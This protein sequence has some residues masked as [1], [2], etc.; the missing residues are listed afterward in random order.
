VSDSR[1][2]GA[3]RPR[4]CPKRVPTFIVI[5][6]AKCGTTS[7]A[8][9]LGDHPEV[10]LTSP[11]EPHYFSRL[12]RYRKL[13]PWYTSLFEGAGS[14]A[15]AG[16]AST[17]YSH[18]HRIDFVAPR[19]RE[20]VPDCRLV[21]MVRHPIRRL[22]SDWKMRLRENRV[23]ASISE[24]ADHHASLISFGLYWKHVETYREYF[25]DD[26]LLVVFLE[27]FAADPR[28]ELARIFRHI[29]VDPTVIP[30]DPGRQRNAANQYRR[31]GMVA[32]VLTAALR[33]LDEY[34]RLRRHLPDW[35][36]GPVKSLLTE[37]FEASP[38]W[39]P[40]ALATVREY[41]RED[42]RQLLRHCGKPLDYWELE[43]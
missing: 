33:R 21:Y 29:R 10:F 23:P 6:A 11:K 9:V 1:P 17:S 37:P 22:E 3:E 18:P 35:L 19:I 38:D 41:Y 8:D 32:K 2:P 31:K 36:R 40:D 4:D 28:R 26:Q 39:E 14:F 42:S 30:D 43:E 27:D 25:P 7:I 5:G 15:A 34:G 20:V 13:R 16:E 12:T 24:A